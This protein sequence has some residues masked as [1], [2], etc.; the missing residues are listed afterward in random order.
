[1]LGQAKVDKIEL[2]KV[3]RI[4]STA[5]AADA[6]EPTDSSLLWDS[7]RIMI[8]LILEAR[9]I[10][11]VSTEFRNHSRVAKKRAYQILNTKGME[12]DKVDL[13]EDLLKYAS[14]TLNYFD[15]THRAVEQFGT[16]GNQSLE[17][18][19]A[20]W[21][22]K[23]ERFKPLIQRVI[24]QTQRQVFNR[25]KVPAEERVFSFFEEHMDIIIKGDREI[26]YGHKLN[27]SSG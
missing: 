16:G 8:R 2:A 7:V 6:H 12:E 25:E 9:R 15:E 19:K 22:G 18:K 3:I 17:K 1:M 20:R 26:Q 10:F 14:A 27:L 4:D 13:Y 24:D 21:L 23:V 5:S 11:D